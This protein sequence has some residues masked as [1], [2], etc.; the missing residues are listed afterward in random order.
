MDGAKERFWF[1]FS[2]GSISGLIFSL[3]TLVFVMPML[4]RKRG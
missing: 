1:S 3:V 4:M 2:I